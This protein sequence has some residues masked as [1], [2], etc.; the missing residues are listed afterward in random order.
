[1][2][3]AIGVLIAAAIGLACAQQQEASKP[4]APPFDPNKFVT[5]TLL[6]ARSN[7]TLGA[8]AAKKGRLDETRELGATMQREQKD[9]LTA[10]SA[11]AKQKNITV[12]EGIEPKRVAL[13]DNLAILPGQVFDRGYSLAMIQD[14]RSMSRQMQR[15]AQS[16][17][18]DL[19]QFARRYRPRLA[20]QEKSASA[21]LK[22]VGGSPFGFE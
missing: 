21:V 5:Q 19:R 3:K 2:R 9:M 17:D 6:T 10:L 16:S 14:L 22:R 13:R 20:E 1:M 8:M 7:T 12:P 4:A 11:L 15:A 18:A